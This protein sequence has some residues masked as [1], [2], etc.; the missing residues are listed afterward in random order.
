MV[1][2]TAQLQSTKFD[3]RFCAGSNP[4]RGLFEVCNFEYFVNYFEE[5]NI[6]SNFPETIF[7]NISSN[8][9]VI[10]KR[11]RV[12]HKCFIE[13]VDKSFAKRYFRNLF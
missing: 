10:N 8:K 1:I 4:A 2:T 7:T 9:G 5:S 12:F 11:C 6:E 3:F 13:I